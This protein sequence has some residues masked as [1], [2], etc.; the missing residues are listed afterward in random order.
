ME[1]KS[2][3]VSI[4]IL[5]SLNSNIDGCPD[6]IIKHACS[7]PS[8]EALRISSR[9]PLRRPLNASRMTRDSIDHRWIYRS[10]PSDL[11]CVIKV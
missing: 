1:C 11:F 8:Q 7:P 6:I 4:R 2:T 3:I 10:F 9:T 5:S